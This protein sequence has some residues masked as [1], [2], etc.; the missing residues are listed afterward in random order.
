MKNLGKIVI[1]LSL[2]TS[3]VFATVTAKV[4]PRDIYA[5][6][7]AT[8]SLTITGSNVKKPELL[9]ICGN[10]I[11]ASSSQTSIVSINGSYK[12]TYTL[13]YQFTPK[14]NC[15]IAPTKVEIDSKEELSNS[16]KV[17]IKP[18]S[19]DFKADFVL[20]FVAPKKELYI[21]EPFELTLLLKQRR[22]AEAVDS[23]Y[24]AP[25]F[26]GFWI[27]SQKEEQRVE[28]G[29][30]TITKVVYKLAPQREGTLHIQPAALKIAQ[31]TGVNNWGSFRPQVRWRTYYSNPIDISAKP[32]PN[33]VKI[34]G[35]FKLNAKVEKKIVNP[36]E[37]VNL[38][39]TVKG[40]GNLEDIESFK[41]Y[42]NSVNIFDEKIVVN[43]N[44]LTQKLVFVG[45]SNFT[46]PSFSLKYFDLK[47]K[48]VK[49]LKTAPIKI[50]VKGN[51]LKKELKIQ[52]DEPAVKV[53][54]ADD[55][56]TVT[57]E[58]TN[59]LYVAL[60]FF[61]GLIVGVFIMI[62]KGAKRSSKNVKIDMKDEKMLL[63]K[64]L[65]FKDID[66]EVATMIEVLENNIYSKEKKQ[67]DKKLLKEMIKKYDIS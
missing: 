50:T 15:T 4:E 67:V 49:I 32:L 7:S 52:R 30:F 18:R 8:Y 38:E 20:S 37:P 21:G 2:L 62:L 43:K 12:K 22:G 33:G 28:K 63:I 42:L 29:D 56:K 48:K 40:D 3:A 25:D 27:K 58:K 9:E 31:R 55:T 41:P 24:I 61:I 54:K 66:S 57:V 6:D 1:L 36:N 35:D 19:Q 34:V 47:T 17:T 13:S 53:V 60:A 16:V 23:K 59:Y 10:D 26:K 14:K 64:L 51:A 45:D 46:I 44:I 5:G 65:P 11:T 39:V